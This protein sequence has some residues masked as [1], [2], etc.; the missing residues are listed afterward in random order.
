ML[1]SCAW[2]GSS[3]LKWDYEIHDLSHR[4]HS[5]FYIF[6]ITQEVLIMQEGNNI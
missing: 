4:L 1:I 2:V 6:F 3:L 5:Y